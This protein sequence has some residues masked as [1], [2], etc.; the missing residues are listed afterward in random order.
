MRLE[1]AP[2]KANA[3]GFMSVACAFA[4]MA[5]LCLDNFLEFG[6]IEGPRLRESVFQLS[7]TGGLLMNYC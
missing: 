1:V 4:A 3:T 7:E 6:C 2:S 5:I